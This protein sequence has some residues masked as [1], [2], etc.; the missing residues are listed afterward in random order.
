MLHHQQLY[1]QSV[2]LWPLLFNHLWQATIF[3]FAVGL[4]ARLLK[5][6]SARAR[7]F[8]WWMAMLKFLLPSASLIWVARKIGMNFFWQTALVAEPFGAARLLHLVEPLPPNLFSEPLSEANHPELYCALTILWLLGG[9]VLLLRWGWQRL[10]FASAAR[11]GREAV[12]EREAAALR[13]VRA[14]LGVRRNLSLMVSTQV[15]EPGLWRIWRPVVILPEGLSAQLS[16]AE[17]DAVLM[18]EVLHYLRRD[19]FLSLVQLL[20]CCVFWFH[21]LIWWLDRR[22]LAEREFACDEGVIHCGKSPQVYAASLWKVA[23]FGVGWAIAGTARATGS[24]LPRRIQYMLTA[25]YQ[26]RLS[27]RNRVVVPLTVVLLLACAAALTF[28]TRREVSAQAQGQVG[29]LEV[30]AET[31]PLP[32]ATTE[33]LVALLKPADFS[34]LKNEAR[35]KVLVVNFWATWC[36]PCLEELPAFVRLDQEYRARGVQVVAISTDEKSQLK[37]TVIPFLKKQKAQ[38]PAFLVEAA[39]PQEL[40]DVV[41]KNWSG[42]LPATF[43]FDKAGNIVL[44]KYGVIQQAELVEKVVGALK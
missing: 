21:P 2:W 35:G 44:A 9:S 27:T 1:E 22:L 7:H 4:A 11:A 20:L 37:S 5:N 30:V 13:R 42:N 14:R 18:H 25:N 32:G 38:F 41:D 36:P 43:V 10:R 17:L 29:P 34:R 33:E 40:I 3:A 8:L 28:F 15:K 6:H 31:A 19:N 16:E 24:N 26:T 39:T 23:Q 12:T